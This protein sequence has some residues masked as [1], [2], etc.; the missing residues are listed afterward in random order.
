MFFGANVERAEVIII[1]F[2]N[3]FKIKQNETYC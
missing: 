1:R 3:N 2:G